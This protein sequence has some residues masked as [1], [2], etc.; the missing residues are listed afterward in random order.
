MDDVI[1]DF[2]KSAYDPVTRKINDHDM[3]EKNFFLDLE[4]V[5]GAKSAVYQLMKMGFDLWILSQPFVLVPE[6]YNQKA[7]WITKHFPQLYNK[8]ILTQDKGLNVGDYLIDDN[9]K[10]WKDKFEQTGGKFIHFPYGGYNLSSS[11]DPERI[12]EDVV[13]FFKTVDPLK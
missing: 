3:F 2:Y 10:K 13:N 6:S 12:W 9:L 8:I 4:P 11:D 5:P 7:E 1:S